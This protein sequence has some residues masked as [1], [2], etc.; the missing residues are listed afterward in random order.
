MS[1]WLK[2]PLLHFLVLGALIFAGY[3]W[4]GAARGTDS[5]DI[6]VSL[7]QQKN[8]AGTFER[9]WQRPPTE[10][11]LE[12]LI[13]DFI[14]QE[15]A[16]RESQA[17]QL[18]RDDIV[19]R[20]R[21]RQKLEMLTED[22]ASLTPPTEQELQ[23]YLEENAADFRIPATLSFRHVYFNTDESREQALQDAESLLSQ[24]H[25]DAGS[26]DLETAGNQSLLPQDLQEVRVSDLDSLFGRGFGE[27]LDDM[28]VG[29]WHG[30]VQSGF[31][32]HLVYVEKR[33]DGH[34]PQLDEVP[35]LVKREWLQVRRK[36]AI[37]S[38]YERLAENYNIVIEA[39]PALLPDGAG[40]SG[41]RP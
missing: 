34:D 13:S 18:D 4:F 11:E 32:L 25:K 33:V 5:G 26:V 21:L 30:P 8:L 40:K 10:G 28:S 24:L 20:R 17:M 1:N 6:V 23:Q 38:L 7:R 35:D 12:G 19:I 27:A 37:A 41:T 16:Y 9:T 29:S 14:R 22:V 39:P 31:G 15:I 3:D 2:E 36:S